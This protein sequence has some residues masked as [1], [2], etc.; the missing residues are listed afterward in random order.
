MVEIENYSLD[1]ILALSLSLEYNY[2]KVILLCKKLA[3]KGY[4]MVNSLLK[5]NFLLELRFFP[6]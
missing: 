2:K 6:L 5:M 3:L 4:R 1:K